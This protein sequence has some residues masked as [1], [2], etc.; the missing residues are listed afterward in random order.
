MLWNYAMESDG[1]CL[2]PAAE[3]VK[4]G[5]RIDQNILHGAGERGELSQRRGH[6]RLGVVQHVHG[7]DAHVGNIQPT[8]FG[9][10]VG[11]GTG[12]GTGIVL[13]GGCVL[14][15]QRRTLVTLDGASIC[16]RA[17]GWRQNIRVARG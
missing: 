2:G 17:L 15:C 7:G 1:G 16:S 13:P 10:G 8:I 9:I 14:R 3:V 12:F 5:S 4:H 11:F 6:R